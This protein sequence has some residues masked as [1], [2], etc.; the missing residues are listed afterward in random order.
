MNGL[1]V[2]SKFSEKGDENL[3]YNPFVDTSDRNIK[4]A[5]ALR[6]VQGTGNSQFS[7]DNPISRQ[8]AAGRKNSITI[9]HTG[10]S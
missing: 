2:N 7:P 9:P 1:N 6:I 5:H 4:I 8:E 3:C 10:G